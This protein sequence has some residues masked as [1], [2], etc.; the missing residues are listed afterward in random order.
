MEMLKKNNPNKG[1]KKKSFST[2]CAGALASTVVNGRG[3]VSGD[4]N[5]STSSKHKN[6]S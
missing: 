5:K 4:G 6:R 1:R 2:S 3:S